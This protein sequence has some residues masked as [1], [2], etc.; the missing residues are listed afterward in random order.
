MD[1]GDPCVARAERAACSRS[2]VVDSLVGLGFRVEWKAGS[3]ASRIIGALPALPTPGLVGGPSG[4]AVAR[5]LNRLYL[6][7]AS[8]VVEPE[9]VR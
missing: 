1:R 6:S 4:N 3:G 2:D 5:L 7:R 9:E 8:R